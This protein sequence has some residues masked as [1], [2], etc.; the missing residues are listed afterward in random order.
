[1]KSIS[2]NITPAG[3]QLIPLAKVLVNRL[4]AIL[5]S[6]GVGVGKTISAGYLLL[7][8]LSKLSRPGLVVCSP[9]LIQKWILELR[10]KFGIATLPIRSLDDLD[11]AREETAHRPAKK[12]QPVYVTS[13][14]LLFESQPQEYPQSSA[15]VFDEIHTYRNPETKIHK[16]CLSLANTASIRVGLSATPINNRLEDL[17]SE[18]RIMLPNYDYEIVDAVVKDLWNSNR[19][20]LIDA[21]TTRFVKE[22][23]GIHFARR[24]VESVRVRYPEDYVLDVVKEIDRRGTGETLLERIT[25]YRLAASSPRAFWVSMGEKGFMYKWEDPKL[26]A[27]ERIVNDHSKGVSHWLV[28]CEFKETVNFLSQKLNYDYLYTITGETPMFDR[29]SI[30]ESFRNSPKGLLI[31]TSVGSEGLDFQFCGGLVNYDLHWNPMRL[32]QRAGR[33]DRVGQERKV[34]QVANIH[35]ENSIDERVLSVLRRKLELVSGSVFVPGQLLPRGS[36]RRGEQSLYNEEALAHELE[37]GRSLVEALRLNSSLD[38]QDYDALGSVD[39][40][41]CRPS[42][43]TA[44]SLGLRSEDVVKNKKW[45]R[46]VTMGAQEVSD[47]LLEYS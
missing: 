37:T 18:F 44:A 21:L 22:K 26:G 10:S 11:T 43:L 46:S 19:K 41:L 20:A 5:I 39:T 30:I 12:E 13:N 14:S 25:Y 8:A 36:G 32:E 6:D 29:P 38:T 16:A 34:I 27:L 28:F 7:Y 35:V 17:S 23:L 40:S 45:I 3:Y 1:M 9:T 42:K 4:N 2:E 47:L 31:T 33:I 24:N 15:I